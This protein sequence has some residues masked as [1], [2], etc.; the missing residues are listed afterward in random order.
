MT[1]P[2]ERTRAVVHTQEFLRELTTPTSIPDVPDAVR[3]EARRLLRHYPGR[4]DM[5][6]THTAM[7]VWWGELP[8][9]DDGDNGCA[10]GWPSFETSPAGATQEAMCAASHHQSGGLAGLLLE[11]YGMTTPGSAIRQKVVSAL[12]QLGRS[13]APS[14][15]TDDV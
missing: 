14:D 11:L 12:T 3:Q 5:R 13:V 4:G 2:H 9:Q 6:L 15:S 8:P 10:S 1:T 7:P